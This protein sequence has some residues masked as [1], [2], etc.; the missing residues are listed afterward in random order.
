MGICGFTLPHIQGPSY[1]G[2]GLILY[3]EDD[4]MVSIN[5]G[6]HYPIKDYPSDI[7]RKSHYELF[8][9][10]SMIFIRVFIPSILF[11]QYFLNP[12][13]RQSELSNFLSAS[14]PRPMILHHSN[15][16]IF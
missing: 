4:E 11:I 1:N 2:Y 13:F 6:Q 7:C 9:L 16:E 3:D 5:L 15:H 12:N 10:R 14:I 8:L